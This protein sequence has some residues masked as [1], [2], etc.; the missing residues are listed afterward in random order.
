MA[1]LHNFADVNTISAAENTIEKLIC[2]L[3][4]ENKTAI[5]WFI[6]NEIILI[7]FRR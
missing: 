3:E 2:T 5:E 7:N 4:K 6:F 1:G